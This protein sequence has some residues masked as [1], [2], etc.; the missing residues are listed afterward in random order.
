[1]SAILMTGKRSLLQIKIAHIHNHP[2]DQAR[3]LHLQIRFKAL[4]G[5]RLLYRING[6]QAVR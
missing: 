3:P 5:H 4:W 6:A 2:Q 1:M